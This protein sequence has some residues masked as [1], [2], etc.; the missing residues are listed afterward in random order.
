MSAVAVVPFALPWDTGR[1]DRRVL[2]RWLSAML[3]V[4]VLVGGV[5]PWLPLPEVERAELE[6]L[7]P[8]L[9]RIVME[10][11][12]PVVPPPP[13][14]KPVEEKVEPRVEEK[15]VPKPETTPVPEPTVADAREKAAVS[16]STSP[17]GLSPPSSLPME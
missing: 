12:K 17:S 2:K 9:A 7:P 5:M 6:E 11:A 14:P 8:Q 15:P 13:P 16:G 3:A 1:A 10:K 4:F